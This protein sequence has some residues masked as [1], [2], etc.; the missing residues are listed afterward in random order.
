MFTFIIEGIGTVLMFFRFFPE[1]N[2]MDALYISVFHSVS[3]FCNADKVSQAVVA[4]ALSETHGRI[5]E[6]IG[7]S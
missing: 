6:K 5:L 4:K 7:A 2:I 1:K 3:A